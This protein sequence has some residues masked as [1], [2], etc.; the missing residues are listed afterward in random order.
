MQQERQQRQ[1]KQ[2]SA[3]RRRNAA[4]LPS[5]SFSARA[6]RL[7]Q[8]IGERERQAGGSFLLLDGCP[9]LL[10]EFAAGVHGAV[11]ARSRPPPSVHRSVGEVAAALGLL[12]SS[13]IRV[14]LGERVK[15]VS[16]LGAQWPRARPRTHLTWALSCGG[17]SLYLP[18]LWRAWRRLCPQHAGLG[19]R[20][21]PVGC[22]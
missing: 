8:Q 2:V 19:R 18:G 11:P 21:R 3:T 17:R 12:L 22:R 7:Q 15:A 13:V 10:P 20:F 4:V 1:Q 6:S 16:R 9:L 5:Q 14:G